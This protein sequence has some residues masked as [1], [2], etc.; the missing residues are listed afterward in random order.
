MV[1]YPI[2]IVVGGRL[3]AVT[4]AENDIQLHFGG[5]IEDAVLSAFVLPSISDAHARIHGNLN[6]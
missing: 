4:F 1:E 5:E 3:Y 6:P 2:Q